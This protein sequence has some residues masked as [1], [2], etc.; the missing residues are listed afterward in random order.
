MARSSSDFKMITTAELQKEHFSFGNDGRQLEST[1]RI[2]DG[3]VAEE[4]SKKIDNEK[5]K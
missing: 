1:S 2:M 3:K 5:E 4:R